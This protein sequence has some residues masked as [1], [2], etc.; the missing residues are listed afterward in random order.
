[1]GCG[2]REYPKL[3]AVMTTPAVVMAIGKSHFKDRMGD[4]GSCL[5]KEG[6]REEV[7]GLGKLGL[8]LLVSAAPLLSPPLAESTSGYLRYLCG[9]RER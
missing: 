9:T 4:R 2:E 8:S 5:C 3:A 7:A 1:M 6:P